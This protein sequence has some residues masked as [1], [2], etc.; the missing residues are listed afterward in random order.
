[1]SD[2]VRGKLA[3]LPGVQVI[4]RGSSVPYRKTTKTPQE[5]ARDLGA[6]YLLM[7]TVRW[8]KGPEASRVHVSPELVDVSPAHA[9]TTKWQRRSTPR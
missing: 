9:P 4:A 1:M 2:E 3:S 6:R 5:I 8:E 7:A